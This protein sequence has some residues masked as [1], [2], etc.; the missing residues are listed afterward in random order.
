MG[1]ALMYFC[2]NRGVGGKL[3]PSK[4]EQIVS[5]A[6]SKRRDGILAVH[7]LDEQQ[8]QVPLNYLAIVYPPPKE[9][10]I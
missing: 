6:N 7:K 8:A 4:R 9:E 2:W 3:T 10:K 1:V 5:S